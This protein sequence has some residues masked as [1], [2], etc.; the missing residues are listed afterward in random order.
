VQ[1]E[2]IDVIQCRF[3]KKGPY[4]IFYNISYHMP[5][6]IFIYFTGEAIS[7]S[8]TGKLSVYSFSGS[9]YPS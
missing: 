6:T 5:Y 2:I 4:H 3:F 9:F 7:I 1:W 8:A